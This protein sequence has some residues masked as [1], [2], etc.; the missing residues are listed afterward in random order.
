MQKIKIFLASSSELQADR[1]QFEIF[2][3]RKCKVWYD[4]GVFLHLDVWE[5]FT[6]AMSA[7]GLQ[8][9]YNKAVSSSDIFVLLVHNKV[10]KYT[11]EEFEKAFGQFSETNKP[12]IFTYFKTPITTQN[13]E[14][15]ESLWA[16]EDKLKVLKHFKTEYQNIEGLRE[17]FGNQL[18]KLENNGF[19]KNPAMKA[20]KENQPASAAINKTNKTDIKGDGNF[21]I[22]DVNGSEINVKK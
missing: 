16:F 3:Y 19:I 20:A 6:D 8:S 1:E 22:Q 7:G 18:A 21:V 12:F 15:I 9:E 4:K 17:H 11:S 5:D 2:I 10:G 14:D 13:R